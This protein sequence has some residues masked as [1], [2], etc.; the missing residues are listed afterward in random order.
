[1]NTPARRPRTALSSN[2]LEQLRELSDARALLTLNEADQQFLMQLSALLKQLREQNQVMH[3]QHV[4]VYEK[5]LN[6]IYVGFV[7]NRMVSQI[8][9]L[10]NNSM[11]IFDEDDREFIVGLA[12]MIEMDEPVDPFKHAE[13]VSKI[14]GALS[15]SSFVL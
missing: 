12:L 5:R 6:E 3:P 15:T 10:S 11:L 7:R 4:M 14:Y 2:A 9:E 1:M 13:R 8:Q